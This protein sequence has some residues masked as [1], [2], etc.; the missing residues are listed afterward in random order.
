[1]WLFGHLDTITH[2]FQYMVE[3]LC[4]LLVLYMRRNW[5]HSFSQIMSQMQIIE[6]IHHDIYFLSYEDIYVQTRNANAEAE[7]QFYCLLLPS[8]QCEVQIRTWIAWPFSAKSKPLLTR[9]PKLRF[10][11]LATDFQ[12]QHCYNFETRF[13]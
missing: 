6:V 8:A 7:C 13:V 1:M 10:L 12:C 9:S 11:L 2:L 4:H 5:R 3:I